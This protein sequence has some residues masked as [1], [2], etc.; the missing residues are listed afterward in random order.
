MNEIIL[1]VAIIAGIGLI[2]GLGL[3]IASVVMAVPKDEKAEKLQEVLPGANCG[4]C[5]F[6]GCAGY[7]AAM[8]KGE[9]KPGLCSPGGEECANTCA[10]LLGVAAESG[11][12][13]TAVVMCMGSGDN[14]SKKLEYQ[15]IGSCKAAAQL[16][17]GGGAC[18]FGCIGLGDCAAACEYDAITVCNGAAIVNSEKCKACGACV[19]ACPHGLIELV[20]LKSSAIVRCSNKDKGALTRN[21]CKTGCIGCM[22]CVKA[23]EH[24]AVK[25][26]DFNAVVD[27]SKCTG[28]G[29]CVD[30][31][32]IGCIKLR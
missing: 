26:V 5:G 14:T 30:A 4:A 9:A 22:M 28:C 20:P 13:K 11:E 12:K 8:S 10:E 3:A 25:V 18:P 23:C 15:G 29:K 27:Y 6:S 31:C 32:K 19:K 7:A 2:A 24:D 17:N 1:A 21:A 16:H